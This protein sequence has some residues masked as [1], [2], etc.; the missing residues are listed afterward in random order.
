VPALQL[1]CAGRLG[2]DAIATALGV[3][4]RG[5]DTSNAFEW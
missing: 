1:G 2:A 5:F 3:G 4:Y